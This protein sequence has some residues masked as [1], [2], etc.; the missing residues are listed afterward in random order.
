[1]EKASDTQT[2]LVRVTG[3]AL[4]TCVALMMTFLAGYYFN[5]YAESLSAGQEPVINIWSDGTTEF[6]ELEYNGERR[7]FLYHHSSG[8]C[9]HCNYT[10]PVSESLVPWGTEVVPVEEKDGS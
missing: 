9:P 6:M 1:M 3:K 8:K 4:C 5:P 7:Q 10:I 2:H